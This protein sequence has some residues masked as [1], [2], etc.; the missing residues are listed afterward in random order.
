MNPDSHAGA[1]TLLSLHFIKTELLPV[2]VVKHVK[3][4]L[5]RRDDVDYGDFDSITA[6]EAR[7]SVSIADATLSS[8]DE[9]RQQL[10][11]EM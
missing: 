10:A 3:A 7:D 11:Q 4:L 2:S 5:S 6:A 9:L 8:I 1:I